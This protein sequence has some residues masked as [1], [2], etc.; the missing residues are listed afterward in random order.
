ML[1]TANL[2]TL[3][4]SKTEFLLSGLQQQLAKIHIAHLILLLQLGTL[5]SSSIVISLFLNIRHVGF[6]KLNIFITR[7]SYACDCASSLQISS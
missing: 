3:N 5:V 2:L 4:S 6:S 1:L 7:P